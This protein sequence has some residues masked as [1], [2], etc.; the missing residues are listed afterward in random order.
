MFLI[1]Y[2]Q[3]HIGKRIL[4]PTQE[5]RRPVSE[6]KK[7]KNTKMAG[8]HNVMLNLERALYSRYFRALDKLWNLRDFAPVERQLVRNKNVALCWN[9]NLYVK[10]SWCT[11]ISFLHAAVQKT[12][13][14]HCS[15]LASQ[16]LLLLTST[17]TF[18][19]GS[20]VPLNVSQGPLRD[21]VASCLSKKVNQGEDS[22]SHNYKYEDDC[23]LGYCAVK[24]GRN[25]PTFQS[26]DHSPDYGSSKHLW[27]VG[28]FLPDYTAQCPRRQSYSRSIKLLTSIIIEII[29]LFFSH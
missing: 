6:D 29:C 18:L 11:A 19:R 20:T 9:C 8:E 23:L 12:T 27:N 25:W 24:S 21:P 10:K 4:R 22:G 17:P 7:N 15:I 13:A 1:P 26:C 14:Q 16:V 5:L 28:E 3:R 2:D